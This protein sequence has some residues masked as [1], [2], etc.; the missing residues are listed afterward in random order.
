[1]EESTKTRRVKQKQAA[2]PKIFE[3]KSAEE[4]KSDEGPAMR[5][6]SKDEMIQA[7]DE[8]EGYRKFV[9]VVSQRNG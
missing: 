9:E 8:Y 1:M 4:P 3:Q 6:E 7:T 5:E 2:S